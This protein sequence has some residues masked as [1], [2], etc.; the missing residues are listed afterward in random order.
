[1]RT[2]IN[3][4]LVAGACALFSCSST[5]MTPLTASGHV[6]AAQ[7]AVETKRT[8]DQ[9]TEIRVDVAHLAPPDK[10]AS[11]A[12]TYVVWTKPP[13]EGTRPQSVGAM[14][15]DKDLKGSL[16]TKTPFENFE[17]LITPE[18]NPDATQPTNEPVLKGKV[19]A[20]K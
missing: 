4:F 8:A 17:L 5:R 15:V 6:V 16:K 11:G 2:L 20:Q 9:N 14:R 3:T 1:M 19:G 7:G 12:T 18:A 13:G 10:V